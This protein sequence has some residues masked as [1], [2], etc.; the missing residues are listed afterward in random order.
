MIMGFILPDWPCFGP[1]GRGC[2]DIER[3]GFPLSSG[4]SLKVNRPSSVAT[5]DTR[6]TAQEGEEMSHKIGF[7]AVLLITSSL[8]AGSLIAFP[9]GPPTMPP[10]RGAGTLTMLVDW[11]VSVFSSSPP[12]EKPPQSKMATQLDPDGN[13]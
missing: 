8:T 9:L 1:A 3:R 2:P 4:A 7:V 5:K 11:V 12:V 6:A 13:H 10:D